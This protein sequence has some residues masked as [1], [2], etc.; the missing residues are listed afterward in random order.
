MNRRPII[1]ILGGGVAGLSCAHELRDSGAEVT[2]YEAG[3]TLG[4]KARSHLMPGTGTQGRG[5]LPGEHG[6]R[7]YPSFYLHLTHA[8]EQIA[9]PLSPTG[10]VAG[11]LTSAPE[12]GV[13]VAGHGVM[14]SPRRPKTLE[15]LKRVMRS[16]TAAGATWRDISRYVVAHL[17][18]LT[19]C[20]GR[21]DDELEQ[22]P[23]ARFVGIED[24]GLYSE[25]FRQVLLSTT[26]TMVA[27]DAEQSSARTV[28]LASTL[29]MLDT[30]QGGKDAIDR[31]MTGPTSACW[32]DP[33]QRALSKKGVQ[34][35]FGHRA[36]EL[37]VAT[38]DRALRR[39]V[40]RKDNGELVEVKA[41]VFVLAV[42]LEAAVSLVTDALAKA[43][44]VFEELRALDVSRITSWMTGAQFYL[45]EDVPL[46]EGHIFFPSTPWA[47]TAISQ[48]QFWNRGARSMNTF[49]DGRLK[50]ILSVDISHCEAP[51]EDGVRLIDE[52]T[53]EG[54][55]KRT[56][57]QLVQSL[58]SSTGA[59][60]E[61][62]VF[63]AHLDDELK[64][65]P[66]GVQ[67]SAR[68]LIHPPGS[69]FARPEANSGLANLFLAGDYLRTEVDLASMEGANES[70]R[71]AALCAL[72]RLE[73]DGSH[74][75]FFE[76]GSLKRF[77]ALRKV[78]E[79]AW[80]LGKPHPFDLARSILSAR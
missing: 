25:S 36:V 20:D 43:S 45:T 77:T 68:L 61:R 55:L 30:V 26:R 24:P 22:L 42:P 39:V 48:A 10:T 63:A 73:L 67:N 44:P 75:K 64:A 7:F 38:G 33:W 12:A 40:F 72:N 59:L 16:A 19:S 3:Q 53:R 34:F 41:D 71:R 14:T 1:A 47:L 60:L 9:D 13:A 78:D 46:V 54:I 51:D 29:L 2:V 49:G 17:Q 21:R 4:G 57:R 80:K 32:L 66:D 62:S 50:G 70:G 31:T 79:L 69:R 6:F 28:G 37:E 58:D 8:M 52:T 76:H 56:L 11:N 74:V 27:M 5:D 18:W 15:D 23:W 35:R 65:G